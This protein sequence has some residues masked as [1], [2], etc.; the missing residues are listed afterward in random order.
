MIL[1]RTSV[2]LRRVVRLY[3]KNLLLREGNYLE[4]LYCKYSGRELPRDIVVYYFII[5]Y[6]QLEVVWIIRAEEVRL[7]GCIPIDNC[8]DSPHHKA[9]ALIGPGTGH[10]ARALQCERWVWPPKPSGIWHPRSKLVSWVAC[11]PK[12]E[13][14]WVSAVRT[15]SMPNESILARLF[16]Q[17]S[18]W[19]SVVGTSKSVYR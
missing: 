4:V 10:L 13:P 15:W 19:V 17:E 8:H 18:R 1:Y 6:W 16:S 11:W 9:G 3:I 2:H 5:L 7:V 14:C 12:R